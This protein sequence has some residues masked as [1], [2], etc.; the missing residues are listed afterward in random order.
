MVGR[1]SWG[2]ENG[3][4]AIP[5]GQE[6]SGGPPEGPGL[7]GL[8]SRRARSGQEALMEG[9]EWSGEHLRGQEVVGRPSLRV[10][11]TSRRAERG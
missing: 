10:G 3:R 11:W 2:A 9:W 5:K 1:P 7:V 8:P 4:K 6:W